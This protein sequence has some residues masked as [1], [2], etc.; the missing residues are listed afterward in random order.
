LKIL[1]V[2]EYP[3]ESDFITREFF[4]AIAARDSSARISTLSGPFT[5]YA[6]GGFRLA[7]LIGLVWVYAALPFRIVFGRYDVV[8]A[9]TTPPGVQNW[10]ALWAHLV[11]AKSICWLMDYHPEIE[12]RYLEKRAWGRP[13]ARVLRAFDR[14]CWRYQD[15]VIVLDEAMRELMETL[16]PDLPI[17]VHPTW[18]PSSQQAFDP[19]SNPLPAPGEPLRM[20]YGGNLGNSHPLEDFERLIQRICVERPVS[21][22]VMGSSPSGNERFLDLGERT[23]AEVKLVPRRPFAEIGQTCAEDQVLLGIV[24][25]MSESAGLVAPSKFAGYLCNGL[26]LLY[27]GP[28]GTSAYRICTEFDGGYHLA[29]D[30]S[31]DE[32]DAMADGLIH[33]EQLAQKTQ[34]VESAAHYFGSRNG[35]TLLDAFQAEAPGLLMGTSEALPG[36]GTSPC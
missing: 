32:I 28:R 6:P 25:L 27:I 18:N 19:V 1:Y 14:A 35:E 22:T 29:V 11:G 17:I 33:L 31:D 36:S 13:L 8:L 24:L 30:A 5:R 26:P 20:L 10:A 4:A 23:G 9:R 16:T 12:A 2:F 7:R 21:I 34:Q 15:A 3:P